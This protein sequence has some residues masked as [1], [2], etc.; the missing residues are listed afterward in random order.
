[1]PKVSR[2][3]LCRRIKDEVQWVTFHLENSPARAVK[4]GQTMRM[5][6][7]KSHAGT[8]KP[9]A[10]IASRNAEIERSIAAHLMQRFGPMLTF[11]QV[12]EVLDFPTSDALERSI[13][14]GHIELSTLKLPHRR[15]T[16]MLAHDLAHYLA[17]LDRQPSSQPATA[18]A[19][20]RKERECR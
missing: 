17:A 1:M 13:Q 2:N 18:A 10:A 6:T 9:D 11:S 19:R 12:A 7:T 3:A 15:G 14:R 20:L 8:Q 4:A 16:F 5:A